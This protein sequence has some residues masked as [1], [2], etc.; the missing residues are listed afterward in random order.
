MAIKFTEKA[1][2]ACELGLQCLF[3]NWVLASASVKLPTIDGRGLLLHTES[4]HAKYI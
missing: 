1:D 2:Q 3:P 4:L